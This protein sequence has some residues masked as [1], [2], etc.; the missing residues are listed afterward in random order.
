M[1]EL[2]N[3]TMTKFWIA[4]IK[5][6]DMTEFWQMLWKKNPLQIDIALPL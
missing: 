2:S 4:Q 3:M 1:E 5:E 6:T